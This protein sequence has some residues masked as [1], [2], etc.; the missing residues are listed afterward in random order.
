LLI[1]DWKL[2][3]EPNAE[4]ANVSEQAIRNEQMGNERLAITNQQ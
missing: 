4:S 2:L 3:I 1:A